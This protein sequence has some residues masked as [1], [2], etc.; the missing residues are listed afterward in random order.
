[1]VTLLSNFTSLYI[2]TVLSGTARYTAASLG[3]LFVTKSIEKSSTSFLKKV[4]QNYNE[5]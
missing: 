5:F 3:H 2:L 4:H 1:M